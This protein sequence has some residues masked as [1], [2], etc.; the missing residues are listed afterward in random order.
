MFICLFIKYILWSSLGP[1]HL[2][3]SKEGHKI[4]T[5]LFLSY[6]QNLQNVFYLTLKCCWCHIQLYTITWSKIYNRF[7]IFAFQWFKYKVYLDDLPIIRLRNTV[8]LQRKSS[9]QLN[10]VIFLCLAFATGRVILGKTT[11]TFFNRT[12]AFVSFQTKMKIRENI[13]ATFKL[14]L[15]L[16]TLTDI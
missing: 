14:K 15:T 13:P 7:N 11:E 8:A 3:G 2:G 4:K 10:K 12:N 5:K 1:H 6:H 16:L 9:W